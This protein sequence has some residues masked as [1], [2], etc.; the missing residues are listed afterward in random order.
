MKTKQDAQQELIK[1]FGEDFNTIDN[2]IKWLNSHYHPKFFTSMEEFVKT[3]YSHITGNMTIDEY[4]DD[5][6]NE[7]EKYIIA[8][9][10]DY[11]DF[12]YATPE[13][14]WYDA[15]VIT[16][17]N[18]TKKIIKYFCSTGFGSTNIAQN[19]IHAFYN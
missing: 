5:Y 18:A 12:N 9:F 2:L 10:N 14:N 7:D 15:I 11:R 1:E 13:D 17:D 8:L 16:Y 4:T 19:D 6:I 3:P